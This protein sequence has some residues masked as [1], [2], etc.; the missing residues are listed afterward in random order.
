[1][2]SINVQDAIVRLSKKLE[3]LDLDPVGLNSNYEPDKEMNPQ[4]RSVFQSLWLLY[5]ILEWYYI[6]LDIETITKDDPL[7][8]IVFVEGE[9]MDDEQFE[10]R[11]YDFQFTFANARKEDLPFRCNYKDLT[12]LNVVFSENTVDAIIRLDR[13][14]CPFRFHFVL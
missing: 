12:G 7:T 4:E 2:R 1:M 13:I 9:Q 10:N 6:R 5:D 8:H 14:K 11:S 3:H